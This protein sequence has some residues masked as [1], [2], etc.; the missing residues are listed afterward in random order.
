M[1]NRKEVVIHLR[2][3]FVAFAPTA[4]WD[5]ETY[6]WI[7]QIVQLLVTGMK[8]GTVGHTKRPNLHNSRNLQ[9]VIVQL[10]VTGMRHVGR[11]NFHNFRNF[12]S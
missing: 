11:R 10:L 7:F 2:Q 5:I 1:S 12:L 9:I 6:Y 4:A 3:E 8:A